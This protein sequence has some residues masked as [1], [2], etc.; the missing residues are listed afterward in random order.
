[1][2]EM[3]SQAQR[4]PQERTALYQLLRDAANRCEQCGLCRSRKNV[5]VGEGSL[6][7]RIMF[8]GEGPGE[9]EDNS[10]RPFVG[11]AGQLLTRI[12]EAAKFSRDDVYIT[13]IVKCRPPNNRVPEIEEV[14][15]CQRWLEAQIAL[16]QPQIIVCLGNT[17][18]K[19]F[20]HGT[21]GITKMRGRWFTWRGAALMPMFHPSYLL[22]NQSRERGGPKDL[23]WR[24]I[25]EIR[26][27]YE[28]LR[29]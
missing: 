3:L 14:L 24:D 19:W 11:P 22:R 15:S 1:M 20:L 5:V 4:S 26:Q 2:T 23:T 9:V 12:L 16:L 18:L 21:E 7:S 17:P 29:G 27:R 8:V 13:N 28:S 25:Q 6:T 10:G